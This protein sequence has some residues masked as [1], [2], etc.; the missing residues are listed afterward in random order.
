MSRYADRTSVPAERSR[1]EIERTLERY[2]ATGFM[3][4]WQE[5]RVMIAFEAHK[6]A[7]RFEMPIPDPQSSEFTM[8]ATYRTR[9][10][11]AAKEAWEQEVRRRWR[12]LGLA[13]KAKLEA[14]ESGIATFEDE[15][16]AYIVTAEGRT[17]GEL[18]RP[19]LAEGAAPRLQL[20]SS[21]ER[22]A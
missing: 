3:Y 20:P 22:G 21:T 12:A 10:Q 11:K 18:V 15:F 2:G 13:I 6:R 14:V 8:T 17:V 9:S 5:D 16:L 1:A 4:A 7:I 19:Q